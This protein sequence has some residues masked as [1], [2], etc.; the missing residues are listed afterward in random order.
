MWCPG[1]R[2][3]LVWTH[4]IMCASKLIYSRMKLIVP[5]TLVFFVKVCFKHRQYV[6]NSWKITIARVSGART[7][8]VVAGIQD[9]LQEDPH[10]PQRP[11]QPGCQAS[12]EWCQPLIGQLWPDFMQR[13]IIF[14]LG[15]RWRRR[16]LLHG[17]RRQRGERRQLPG[18]THRRGRR[19]V[20]GSPGLAP[21]HLA[22]NHRHWSEGQG[23]EAAE[24]LSPEFL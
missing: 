14:L 15:Q 4:L 3:Q 9:F 11:Q 20:S 24:E 8:T 6:G 18:P 1:G 21:G 10:L 22:D 13:R 2:K 19:G 16:L 7:V 5:L 17:Q 23:T 12:G